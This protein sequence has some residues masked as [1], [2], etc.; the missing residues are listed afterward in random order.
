MTVLRVE[1]P[2]SFRLVIGDGVDDLLSILV[3]KNAAG[4]H[5]VP[6]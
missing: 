1:Q 3:R 5:E 6:S 2:G 4:C